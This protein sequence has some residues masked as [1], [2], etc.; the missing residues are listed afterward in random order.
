MTDGIERAERHT[1]IDNGEPCSIGK[2]AGTRGEVHKHAFVYEYCRRSKI[3][4]GRIYLMEL[5]SIGYVPSTV[6]ATVLV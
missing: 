2:T 4:S 5:G 6:T 1:Q 3:L